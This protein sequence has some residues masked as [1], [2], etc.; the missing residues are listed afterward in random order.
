MKLYTEILAKSVNNGGTKLLDHLKH[1]SIVAEKIAIKLNVDI[2]TAIYGA[3]LH[4]IGKAHPTFQK[5]LKGKYDNTQIAFRHEIASILFLPL[6]EKEKWGDLTDLIIAHHRSPKRDA[7]LQGII[8]LV[9]ME[10]EEEV[11]ELHSRE[12][13]EWSPI[14][15]QILNELGVKTKYITID[16]AYKA[17][18]FVIAHC[19]T[20][21]LNWS[22]WKGVIIGADHLASAMIDRIQSISER[23][24]QVP[25]ISFFSSPHRLNKIYPLSLIT[26]KDLR[27][28]TIVSAPTGAGKTDFLI[29]RCKGRIFYTLPFQ[30]SINSMYERLKSSCPENTDIRLL[31]AASR[32]VVKNNSY[33]EKVL[34]NMVGSAIKVLTPHQL[35]ALICGTRGFE[36]IAIDIE[37]CDVIL[38]EIHSYSDVAQAMV[39]EIIKILLKLNCNIHVGSATMPSDLKSKIIKILGGTEQVYEVKLTENELDTFNRHRIIKHQNKQS[40]SVIIDKAVADNEKILIVT[41]RVESAQTWYKDLK[42][43]YD[44]IPILLIHSRFRRIDR[45]NLEK[46]LIN[47]YNNR[48]KMPGCCI[49]VSTQVVEVSLDISFDTM[50][51]DAA[52]LDS[53]IQRFGR[54]NRYRSIETLNMQDIKDIHVIAPP[55]NPRDC[56]P[57]KKELI[58][59]SYATLPNN[60]VL[61]EKDIQKLIDEVYPQVEIL[62][63]DVH[64]AWDDEKF[65][66]TEL[67]HL[68]KASLLEMLNIDSSVCIRLS[69]KDAY[70]S[71]TFEER[72]SLEI[73]VPR[74][75]FFKK[76]TKY[77]KSEYGNKPLI[78]DDVLYDLNIGLQWK[79]IEQ[80]V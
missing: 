24:F 48:K 12:W 15:L 27:R 31:H 8:D 33:E 2:K 3:Y 74:T 78:I 66:L 59:K 57:Y 58:D 23:L 22:I 80:F 20:K 9:E 29:N 25:D 65:L 34:Q 69:D 53:L 14:A 45:T 46:E 18:N 70:E 43:R 71:G 44:G 13:E 64:L 47:N 35:A 39:L 26:T 51:T 40:T 61:L 5:K 72:L 75:V 4:D 36:V 17:F 68:P 1:V 19:E 60:E 73:P 38:D 79:E 32:V 62:P 21:G 55:E 50:I 6:F 7:R 10:G 56:L 52:P 63:I 49:V 16:E 67:C 41:N 54:I 28:H 30:A 76:I 37:G 11:F 77:G 42:K